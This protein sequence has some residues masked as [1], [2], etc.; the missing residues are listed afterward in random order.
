MFTPKENKP[1]LSASE[2]KLQY[3]IK[4]LFV[5][6][7]DLLVRTCQKNSRH[8]SA[9]KCHTDFDIVVR[10]KH[11]ALEDK[12]SSSSI[13]SGVWQVHMVYLE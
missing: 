13:R 4:S 8:K 7:T 5:H 1:T 2:L 11:T 12:H 9:I 3:F 10:F 6:K